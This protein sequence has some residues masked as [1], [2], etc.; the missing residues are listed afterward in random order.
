MFVLHYHSLFVARRL[1]VVTVLFALPSFPLTQALIL[2]SFVVATIFYLVCA[3]P[4]A[5]KTMLVLEI[6]N[7]CCLLAIILLLT[8]LQISI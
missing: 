5:E 8:S 7:E 3:R 2:A 4:L 6:F 1:L